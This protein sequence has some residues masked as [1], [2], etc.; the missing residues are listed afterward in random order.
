MKGFTLLELLLS[1]SIIFLLTALLATSTARAK[2]AAQRAVCL[3]NARTLKTT[4][5][6]D[7]PIIYGD[8]RDSHFI[9]KMRYY[10][11]TV[12]VV[13]CYTCHPFSGLE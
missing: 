8:A 9:E 13:N 6:T 5:M 7:V 12:I 4:G 3:N 11:S 10:D 2:A 1:I